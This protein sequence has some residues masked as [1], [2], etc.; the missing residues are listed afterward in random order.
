MAVKTRKALMKYALW[1]AL[2]QSVCSEYKKNWLNVGFF[3]SLEP[4]R[5]IKKYNF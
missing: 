3:I 1:V 2:I 4:P 5:I